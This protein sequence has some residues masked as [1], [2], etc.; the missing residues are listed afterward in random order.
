[1]LTGENGILTQAQNAKNRT[2]EAEAEERAD[3]EEQNQL[4]ENLANGN[5]IL[6]SNNIHTKATGQ[7][8]CPQNRDLF[9]S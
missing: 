6:P 9:H 8:P 4:I 7:N 5:M 1:M 2:A 3:L